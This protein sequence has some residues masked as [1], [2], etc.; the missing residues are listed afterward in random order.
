VDQLTRT[1]GVEWFPRGVRVNAIAAW[2]DGM[3]EADQP[4]LEMIGRS[5]AGR[6]TEPEELAGTAVYLA[7]GA[8]AR[9]TGQ[10]VYVDGGYT[11]Q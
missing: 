8:S 3:R 1:L 9:V 6:M 5:P 10:I 11:A 2:N 4:L 7:S